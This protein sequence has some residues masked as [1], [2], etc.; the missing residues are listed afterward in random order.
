ME[1]NAHIKGDGTM[2]I[3]ELNSAAAGNP[4]LTPWSSVLFF[5]GLEDP[6]ERDWDLPDLVASHLMEDSA[7]SSGLPLDLDRLRIIDEE[8]E[9][10]S[11][12]SNDDAHPAE[13]YAVEEKA[14]FKLDEEFAQ[15]P[16]QLEQAPAVPLREDSLWLSSSQH[17]PSSERSDELVASSDESAGDSEGVALP[18][19]SPGADPDALFYCDITADI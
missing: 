13:S 14:M 8:P 7:Q 12:D 16:E 15:Q 18:D 17:V 2:V 1:P 9:E 6:F 5:N 11:S 19:V 3:Y 10:A 4:P